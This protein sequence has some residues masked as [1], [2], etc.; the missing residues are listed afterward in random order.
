MTSVKILD[1]WKLLILTSAKMLAKTTTGAQLSIFV[2]I[3][4]ALAKTSVK[5]ALNMNAF[6]KNARILYQLHPGLQLV[7]KEVVVDTL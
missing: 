5:K 3:V 6:Y 4:V 2:K 1:I 7:T